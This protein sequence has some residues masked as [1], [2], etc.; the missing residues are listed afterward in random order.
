MEIGVST[1]Y[2]GGVDTCIGRVGLSLTKHT[3][4]NGGLLL[5]VR[6]TGGCTK[7]SKFSRTRTGFARFSRRITPPQTTGRFCLVTS[8]SE[9]S[10]SSSDSWEKFLFFNAQIF[11]CNTHKFSSSGS[12]SESV[13]SSQFLARSFLLVSSY[14]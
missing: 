5:C 2:R 6:W 7:C 8:G 13:T 1:I 12:S 9:S 11:F 3:A 10:T 4:T 14:H